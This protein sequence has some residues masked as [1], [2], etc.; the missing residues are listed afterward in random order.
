MIKAFVVVI[1]LSSFYAKGEE[2]STPAYIPYDEQL[3]AK[4]LEIKKNKDWKGYLNLCR[5]V[6]KKDFKTIEG[7][8]AYMIC[9]DALNQAGFPTAA[10]HIALNLVKRHPGSKPTTFALIS[11]EQAAQK[12]LLD[13]NEWEAAVQHLDINEDIPALRSMINY[14]KVL[15]L[16]KLKY[17]VWQKKAFEQ[18]DPNSYWGARLQFYDGINAFKEGKLD[19][20]IASFEAI[21]KKTELPLRFTE[22]VKL[23][24]AR[25]YFEKKDLKS[26]D[27]LYQSYANGSRDYGRALLER[28]WIDFYRKEY[29]KALGLLTV[30]KSNFFSGMHDPERYLLKVLIYREL[31][32]FD[33]I[34]KINE[35]F[36]GEYKTLLDNLKN[37][38]ALRTDNILLGM[39][40][41]Y[42]NLQES[43]D[44]VHQIR[45]ER[46]EWANFERSSAFDKFVKAAYNAKE[47]SL[48][49]RIE[50]DNRQLMRVQA[51]NIL[52]V[53][54]QLQLV[55]Y[56]S[57]LEKLRPKNVF[58][59][60]VYEAEQEGR[61]SYEKLYWPHRNEFWW[62]EL[63]GYRVLINDKCLER[64]PA[65]EKK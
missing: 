7:A 59:H 65:G 23:Q 32:H 60:K 35:E 55:E 37:D 30:L 53:K 61:F 17:T 3:W 31:C 52:R 20:A 26:A 45:S 12:S 6:F 24:L 47:R 13:S 9:V 54:D 39:T 57:D 33:G 21:S 48:R 11:V 18:V 64:T 50:Y 5:S 56:V 10:S 46:K 14:F 58:T 62:G 29:S 63:N 41:A 34:K 27:D 19:E 28:G 4:A 1:L 42:G 25:L 49:N 22:T 43:A 44:L 36:E 38:K 51:E 40:L 2:T 8:E 15:H 16:S